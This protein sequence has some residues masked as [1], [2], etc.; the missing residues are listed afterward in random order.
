MIS[1]LVVMLAAVGL[2][3]CSVRP[4]TPATKRGSDAVASLR[5]AGWRRVIWIALQALAGVALVLLV[6]ALR[7]GLYH[8]LF[9]LAGGASW[10]ASA[11][12]LEPARVHRLEVR[13]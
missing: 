3:V 8:V 7:T 11:V 1:C 2:G 4:D 5:S 12:A 13:A 6:A 9:T 10:L